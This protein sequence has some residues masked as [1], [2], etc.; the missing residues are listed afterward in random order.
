MSNECQNPN[1][2]ILD[3]RF[4]MQKACLPENALSNLE[5][6]LDICHYLVA[7]KCGN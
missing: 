4:G 6:C 1:A 3:P 2:E 7:G 5:F